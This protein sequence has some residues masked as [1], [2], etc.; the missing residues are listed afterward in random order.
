VTDVNRYSGGRNLVGGTLH[1]APYSVLDAFYR[2]NG[3]KYKSRGDYSDGYHVYG[4][5]WSDS[6]IYTYVDSRLAV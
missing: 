1:W 4:M 6:Y 2:T 3:V 5:E